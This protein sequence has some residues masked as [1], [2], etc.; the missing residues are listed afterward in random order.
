METK[1]KARI[2]LLSHVVLRDPGDFMSAWE[3]DELRVKYSKLLRRNSLG[4]RVIKNVTQMSKSS[5][6]IIGRGYL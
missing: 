5:P 1:L 3:L 2:S 6:R 4:I